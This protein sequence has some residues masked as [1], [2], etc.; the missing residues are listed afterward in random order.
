[1][2]WGT[3]PGMVCPV[4]RRSAR[5]ER[6]QTAAEREEVERAL[7]YMGLAAGTSIEEITLDRVFIEQMALRSR[8]GRQSTYCSSTIRRY[9]CGMYLPHFSP[10]IYR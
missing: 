3:N 8:L 2:T 9:F 10:L 7:T 4:D 6:F 1:M 5:A